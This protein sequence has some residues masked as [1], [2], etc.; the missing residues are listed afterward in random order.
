MHFNI[1]VSL[2]VMCLCVVWKMGAAGTGEWKQ[3]VR[4]ELTD[5]W[6]QM[7]LKKYIFK[8]SAKQKNKNTQIDKD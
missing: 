7:E 1:S 8:L 2:V 3:D 6:A 5:N 4:F